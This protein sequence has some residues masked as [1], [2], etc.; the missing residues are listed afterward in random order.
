[1]VDAC[2]VMVGLAKNLFPGL[3]YH[4][5]LHHAQSIG[6]YTKPA[7]FLINNK[8]HASPVAEL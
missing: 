3:A 1:M 2:T 8:G 4:I 5:S 7:R 6:S